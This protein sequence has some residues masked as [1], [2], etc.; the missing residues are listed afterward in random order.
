MFNFNHK[1]IAYL[2]TFNDLEKDRYLSYMD[3]TSEF[4]KNTKCKINFDSGIYQESVVNEHNGFKAIII[5][6]MPKYSLNQYSNK[7]CSE[8]PEISTINTYFFT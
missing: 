5:K 7:Y 6:K 8:C 3:R 1:L 4:K 2:N